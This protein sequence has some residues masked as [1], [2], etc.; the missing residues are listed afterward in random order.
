[1]ATIRRTKRPPNERGCLFLPDSKSGRKT[2]VLNA[3]ALAVLN[4][5]ERL[6][7][8][9][10]PGDDSEHPFP[11][12]RALS[13]AQSRLCPGAARC[14]ASSP[15]A[16]STAAAARVMAQAGAAGYRSALTAIEWLQ[17]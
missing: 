2:V 5:L 10:V 11:T 3:P 14:V 13:W 6:G 7:P 8:Y 17:R 4:A 9:V 12:G 15:P 16:S 1:M